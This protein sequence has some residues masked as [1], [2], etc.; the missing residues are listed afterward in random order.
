MAQEQV[1]IRLARVQVQ[2]LIRVIPKIAVG[3]PIPQTLQ[4][5]PIMAKII[6]PALT[7]EPTAALMVPTL[8]T[9]TEIIITI[10]STVTITTATIIATTIFMVATGG[11]VM[12][13][14]D[15]MVMVATAALAAMATAVG[16]GAWA[17][18]A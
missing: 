16:V 17:V 4:T 5:I 13:V 14:M 3:V 15:I 2:A 11:V 7:G 8:L 10:I 12:V 1:L 18:L 6:I 9:Q